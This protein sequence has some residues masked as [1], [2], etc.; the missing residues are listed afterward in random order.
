MSKIL[1]KDCPS[2]KLFKIEDNY[3]SYCQWGKRK[4]SK[5]LMDDRVRK[6]CNLIKKVE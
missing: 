6:S 5:E 2:C 1:T 4:K 3:K